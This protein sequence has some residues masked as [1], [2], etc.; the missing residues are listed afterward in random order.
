MLQC[1]QHLFHTFCDEGSQRVFFAQMTLCAFNCIMMSFIIPALSILTIWRR[2]V[3]IA[4]NT[5]FLAK[6]L[7]W[8]EGKMQI[9]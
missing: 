2:G 3:L 6:K 8:P 5:S 7:D 4:L 9:T 1:Q